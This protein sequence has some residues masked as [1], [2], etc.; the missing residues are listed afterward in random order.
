MDKKDLKIVIVDDS[1][2]YYKIIKKMLNSIGFFDLTYFANPLEFVKFFK[3]RDKNAIDLVFIDYEM[4]QM[5]GLKVLQYIKLHPNNILT[6]MITSVKDKTIKQKAIEYGVN[7]FMQKDIDFFSFQTKINILAN[8]RF[9]YYNFQTKKEE[10]ERLISYKN[11]QETMAFTKQVKIIED[12]LSNHFYDDWL[13]DSFFRPKDILSGDSYTTMPIEDGKF[14]VS[15]IDGM[16]KGISAS[17][18]SILTASFISHS[19]SKSIHFNDFDFQRLCQDT[20]EYAKDIM[21]DDEALSFAM[22]LIDLNKMQISYTN[23]GLPPI[24]IKNNTKITKFKPNNPPLLPTTKDF[25]IDTISED[26]ESILM[27]SDGYFEPI[28]GLSNLPYFTKIPKIYTDSL[29]LSELIK[30]FN[31]NISTPTDDT[32]IVLFAKD[33]NPYK[34]ILKKQIDLQKNNITFVID[35][36][37]AKLPFD[38]QL[39]SKIVFI[40]NEL[41]MNSYEHGAIGLGKKKHILLAQNKPIK[42]NNDA[43]IA[44]LSILKSQKFVIICLE[45][46]GEGFDINKTLKTQWFSKYQGRGVKMIKM[47]SDGMYYNKKGNKVKIYIKI[48]G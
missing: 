35:S 19:I 47:I 17:L 25:C 4:P 40:T 32:T 31:Q 9:Y 15:I 3:K 36:L 22:V 37:E 2:S 18:T 13:I 27:F 10:L 7:E 14:F 24:Y 1:T 8:L 6:I 43:K 11:K 5:N 38:E 48:K 41:L 23:M 39:N 33:I 20:F 30:D 16:G 34:T 45:D 44:N 21:L 46:N 26:F 28:S 42:E 12:Q 29:L